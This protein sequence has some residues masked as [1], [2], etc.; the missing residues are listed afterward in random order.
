MTG[1]CGQCG[2]KKSQFVSQ[3]IGQGLLGKILGFKDGRIPVLSDIPL[4]GALL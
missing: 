4:I 1:I 3:Q 2:A